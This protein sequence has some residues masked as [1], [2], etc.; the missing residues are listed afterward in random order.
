MQISVTD[1]GPGIPQRF[2]QEVFSRFVQVPE[3]RSKRRGAGLG[4]AYC[5]AAIEAHGEKIW[6]EDGEKGVGTRVIF[7]L[8]VF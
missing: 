4:L 3:A 6:I 5:Q 2:R 8:P 7:T 1:T